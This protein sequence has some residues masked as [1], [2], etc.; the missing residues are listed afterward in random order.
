[1]SATARYAFHVQR[2]GGGAPKRLQAGKAAAQPEKVPRVAR[3][4][5]LAHKFQGMLDRG[6]AASMAELARLGRVSRARITQIMDLLMLAPEIQEALLLGSVMLRLRD[7]L[8]V[9][10]RV[11]WSEQRALWRPPER[12][13]TGAHTGSGMIVAVQRAVSVASKRSV[14][15]RA[16]T[17][18]PHFLSSPSSRTTFIIAKSVTT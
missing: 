17:W 11:P 10:R 14:S 6:E 16:Y 7:L 2:S 8:P 4:L 9:L 13:P 5:A 1:M 15:R 3:L 18:H 12:T